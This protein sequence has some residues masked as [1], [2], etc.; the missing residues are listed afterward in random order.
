MLN[1]LKVLQ[2]LFFLV[3]NK[4]LITKTTFFLQVLQVLFLK[5]N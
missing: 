2:F 4:T 1:V 3:L 5:I